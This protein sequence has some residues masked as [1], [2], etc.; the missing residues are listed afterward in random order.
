[1]GKMQHNTKIQTSFVVQVEND[2]DLLES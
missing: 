1:V 2:H